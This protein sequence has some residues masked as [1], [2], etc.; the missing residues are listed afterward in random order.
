MRLDL[1]LV[2]PATVCWL[3]A[4]ILVTFP[5]AA[6]MAG[7]TCWVFA[8]ACL[9]FLIGTARSPHRRAGTGQ[10]WGTLMVCGAA[11]GLMAAMVVVSA[12]VRL[13]GEVRHAAESHRAVGITATVWS[14]PVSVTGG[15]GAGAGGRV[16]F[17]ATMTSLSS[18]YG[19]G[20]DHAALSDAAVP[21]LVYAPAPQ[22]VE[23][24]E[25]TPRIG[26]S[27]RLVGTLRLTE[28]GDSAAALF[29]A[30]ERPHLIDAPGWVL[31]WA[32]ELRSGFARDAA[33][34]PGDGGDLLPGLAIGDT[35]SV[36]PALDDA[37]KASAL[38]HLTAV[39][40][41]TKANRGGLCNR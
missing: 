8:I 31:R 3:S 30:D 6:V 41:D 12:P 22:T 16:R 4:G 39:S 7:A 15:I 11:A 32:D 35:T 9:G 28:P 17:R 5:A 1:R 29:Y 36:R 2:V 14:L 38:S 23:A 19:S 26:E 27:V 34:L 40:G 37:M 33:A 24:G 21:L 25:G 13:P 20:A 10:L 18:A